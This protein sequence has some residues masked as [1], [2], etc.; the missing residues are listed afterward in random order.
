M[1]EQS[2]PKYPQVVVELFGRDGNV[3]GLL[4]NTT[5]ALRQAGVP[6]DECLRF[7]NEATSGSYDHA[8]QTIQKWVS[9]E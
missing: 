4:A 6:S 5:R 3:F 7:R 8:L 9:V 1:T 2:G